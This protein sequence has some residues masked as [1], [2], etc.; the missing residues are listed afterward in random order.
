MCL[1][2]IQIYEALFDQEYDCAPQTPII[3]QSCV[4][5]VPLETSAKEWSD[6]VSF[7]TKTHTQTLHMHSYSSKAENVQPG[8]NFSDPQRSYSIFPAI[9]KDP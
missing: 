5:K 6:N 7:I 9:A 8:P 3:F 1:L 2:F 4:N